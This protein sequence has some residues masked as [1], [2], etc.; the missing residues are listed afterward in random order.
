MTKRTKWHVCPAKTPPSLIRVYAVSMKKAWDLSDPLSEQ[1]RLLL[2]WTDAQA[3][4]SLRWAHRHFVGFVML[5]LIC[6]LM[7]YVVSNGSLELG[8]QDT[9]NV[10]WNAIVCILL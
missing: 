10:L 4:L 2:D 8:K 1:R 6:N 3:D 7:L 5:L 9:F